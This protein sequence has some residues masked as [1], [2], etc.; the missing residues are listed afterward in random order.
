MELHIAI[1]IDAT[2]LYYAM[3]ML[4]SVFVHNPKEHIVVHLLHASMTH[5]DLKTLE[6]HIIEHGGKLRGYSVDKKIFE[7]F[8][9][10]GRWAIETYFRLL[11]PEVI[12]KQ[13][14]RILYLDADVIVNA[15]LREL[16]TKDFQKK[17]LIACLNMDGEVDIEKK[18][19]I[20]QREKNTPYF[21]A[22]VMLLNLHKMRQ[23]CD[24]KKY[25]KIIR[26]HMEWF[27]MMDQDLLNYVYGSDIK[28]IE[29]E[30]YNYIIKPDMLI[31]DGAVI[32]HFGTREKPWESLKDDKY[33]RIW[34]QYK[35]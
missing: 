8:P 11:L 2:Y 21:N 33:H 31:G 24:I 13:L 30:K 9:R 32:Y 29:P 12:P 34:W 22:G 17:S 28:Y 1:N 27:P 7:K 16:Y 3:T 19:Q 25:S 26:E 35:K 18:N 20:W 5:T 10:F 6:E 4:E 15:S 14:E 23:I